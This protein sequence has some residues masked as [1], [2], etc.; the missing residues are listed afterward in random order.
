MFAQQS[1]DMV[2]ELHGLKEAQTEE[3]LKWKE[4]EKRDIDQAWKGVFYTLEIQV[5]HKCV[6][7]AA[8]RGEAQS[9]IAMGS[10]RC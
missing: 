7:E 3:M 1:S 2:Q 6:V 8:E 4:W 10:E 9:L 5:L